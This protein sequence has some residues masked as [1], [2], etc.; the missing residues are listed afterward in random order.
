MSRQKKSSTYTYT[1]LLHAAHIDFTNTICYFDAASHL[2]EAVEKLTYYTSFPRSIR[3]K[4]TVEEEEI[5]NKK[6]TDK[7]DNTVK[8]YGHYLNTE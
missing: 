2:T 1:R 5:T 7:F 8:K 3:E 4:E 6:T